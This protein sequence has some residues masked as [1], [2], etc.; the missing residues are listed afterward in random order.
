[1][2]KKKE[3]GEIDIIIEAK[4]Y[5]LKE[6]ADIALMLDEKYEG[7]MARE[8][9]T[10]AAEDYYFQSVLPMKLDPSLRKKAEASLKKYYAERA[11]RLAPKETKQ[12]EA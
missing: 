3:Y 6:I 8:S 12:A 1:M 7:G 4:S 11:K 5:V 2:T 9:L 10:K